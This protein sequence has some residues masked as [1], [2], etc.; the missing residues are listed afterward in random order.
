MSIFLVFI[1]FVAVFDEI[2]HGV[3]SS[4]TPRQK[5]R[6]SSQG[7]VQ[8]LS[9]MV[10]NPMVGPAPTTKPPTPPQVSR[11]SSKGNLDLI[12]INEN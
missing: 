5:L 12:I 3:K 1:Q 8:S 2:G 4:G 11:T 6:G 10:A 7:S 9:S